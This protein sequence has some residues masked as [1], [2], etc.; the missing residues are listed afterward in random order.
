MVYCISAA[1]RI[2]SLDEEADGRRR[3][4]SDSSEAS[5]S[6]GSYSSGSDC[7]ESENEDDKET[8]KIEVEYDETDAKQVYSVSAAL[9][10]ERDTG[11]WF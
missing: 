8:K 4:S 11:N 1:F 3:H 6:E 9:L 10:S 2:V 5:S 7:S